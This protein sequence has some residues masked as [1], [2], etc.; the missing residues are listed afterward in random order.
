M[1][2]FVN[3]PEI[4][5]SSL[6]RGLQPGNVANFLLDGK[7]AA[8]TALLL[9]DRSYTY[10]DLQSST[11][12]VAHYLISQGGRKGERVILAGEN[13]FFW[14][15]AYLGTLLAGMVSV[16]VAPNSAPE[17][18]EQIARLT[19]PRFAFLQ[20]KVAAANVGRFGSAVVVTDASRGAGATTG[21]DEVRHHA[22]D[23]RAE[24]PQVGSGE[25]A[26]I[27]FTSGST[28]KPR[29]VKISHRN[30]IANTESIIQYLKL[31]QTDRIMAVL[32][33]Y[34]C[35]GAS[36]LHTHLRVGGSVVLDLRFMYPDTV[37]KRMVET[38]CTGFAGVPSHYQ[39]LLRRSSLS[40]MSFPALRYLQQAGGHL[41]PVFV[42]ELQAAL[43]DTTLLDVW[44]NRSHGAS[45]LFASGVS[46]HQTGFYWKGHSRCTPPGGD[47]R[48]NRRGSASDRGNRCRR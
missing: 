7:A 48:G 20:S 33:L 9:L 2:D 18:L 44:T 23:P 43:P 3:Q 31:N 40:R 42:R 8:D 16:P 29:G 47:S 32:P 38:R 39:I 27:I 19:E 5:S 26:A 24:V 22:L 37:L 30:I 4:A 13:S 35:F 1:P 6:G 14:V 11:A 41:A 17:D 28:G 46:W 45:F 21:F 12:A 34:Y 15:S 36:L 10:G 25:L